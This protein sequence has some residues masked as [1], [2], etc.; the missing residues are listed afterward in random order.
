MTSSPALLLLTRHFLGLS[1]K[2]K[3]RKETAV[4]NIIWN[5]T[6][7]SSGK[8]LTTIERSLQDMTKHTVDLFGGKFFIVGEV[9]CYQ[10]CDIGR[11][12]GT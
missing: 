11:A 5:E 4:C 1:A 12:K 6:P 7:V 10:W 9:K 3:V 2:A 8:A